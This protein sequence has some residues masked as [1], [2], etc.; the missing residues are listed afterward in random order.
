MLSKA[1]IGRLPGY[2]EYINSLPSHTAH[3]SATTIARGLDLGEV[4]VRKD[5]SAVCGTGKP[6]VGYSVVDLSNALRSALGA[7]SGCEAVIVGAGKL[8]MALLGFGGFEDYGISIRRAFD[9]NPAK[10][11]SQILPLDSLT[12]YCTLHQVE[13]GIITTPAEA[14]QQVADL[15]VKSGVRAI[16]CF[17]AARLRLPPGITVQYENMAPALAHL[18][19][20]IKHNSHSNRGG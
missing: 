7:N 15:L 4:Q 12:S 19:H 16:W 10:L 8:G 5:L 6:R 18:Y 2:L 3:I 11:S 9:N 20:K 13:I 17:S 1:T 14:A